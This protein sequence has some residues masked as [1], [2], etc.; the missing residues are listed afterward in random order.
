MK[1]KLLP[2]HILI[3]FLGL[4]ALGACFSL[5]GSQNTLWFTFIRNLFFLSASSYAIFFLLEKSRLA[6]PSR[7][8]H[9]AIT[10]LILFL[11]FDPL[12]PWW[13]FVALGI[14]TEL[15]QRL[16]RTKLGPLFN[17]VAAS[18]LLL[19]IAGFAPSWWGVS[20]APRFPVLGNDVSVAMILTLLCAGY[21]AYRYHK[22]PI[23]FAALGA[24]LLSYFILFGMAPVFIIAEGT[25]LF[26][27]LVMA[28]EPKTSP[29]LTQ[30]Q[31]IFGGIIGVAL[32]LGLSFHSPEAYLGAI[33]VGNLYH[34]RDFLK[35]LVSIK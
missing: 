7:L 35:T 14:L 17:P 24:F 20:F 23:A 34:K 29:I 16:V 32:T 4:L 5:S 26:F 28:V 6:L 30:E 1:S 10:I 2:I 18:G 3:I 33:I 22:F 27:L 15:L 31:Y 9:R 21:V 12:S 13:I 19:S 25:L 11:L 8:E